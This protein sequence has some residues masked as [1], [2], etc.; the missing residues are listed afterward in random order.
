MRGSGIGG[1]VPVGSG[2][3][4]GATTGASNIGEPLPDGRGSD[5]CRPEPNLLSVFYPTSVLST[6]R[7]IITLWVARMV[8]AGL[9]NVGKVPFRDV[10]IHPVIQDGQGRQMKKSLGNG[11][12]PV[13]IIDM[14]GADALRFTLAGMTTE[15]QDVRIPVKPARL[16]DGRTVNSSEKFEVGRNFCNKLWQA[17]T[18]YI[19]PNVADVQIR[20]HDG[21]RH[22]R[23]RAHELPLFDRWIRTR[24]NHCIEAVNEALD[25][26]QF[27]RAADTVRDF[28]WSEFCDWYLEESKIR[29]RGD[30]ANDVKVVLLQVLDLTLCLL[31]PFTPFITEAL[32]EEIGQRIPRHYEVIAGDDA[33]PWLATGQ[34][35]PT[36]LL[37]ETP[38]PCPHAPFRDD[39]CERHI[40]D[41]L[42]PIILALRQARTDVNVVRTRSG[43]PAIRALPQAG[44]RADEAVCAIVAENAALIGRLGSVER[45]EFGPATARPPRARSHV[46]ER[47]Q[48]YVPLEGLV[49]LA[50]ETQRLTAE[51]EEKRAA[52]QRARAQ[53][54]NEGFVQRAAPQMVQQTRD[55]AAELERQ[56][57][58]LQQHLDDLR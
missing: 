40:G 34:A 25:A 18:G 44:L 50:V 35:L 51:L 38:W 39:R 33:L 10:F 29:I 4:R 5:Q 28:F 17:A 22:T 7:E 8:I 20:L 13:D 16:P 43:Q 27:A 12:D 47:F 37:I 55:R 48:M 2:S 56:C 36:P 21:A 57:A 45:L 53:L 52:L 41:V 30:D 26:Y 58:L 6:A 24:L 14:Y 11:V 54:A 31:H 46:H 1:P 3:D 49:D 9:Y 32:W 15:T 42:Q 19:L 23:A